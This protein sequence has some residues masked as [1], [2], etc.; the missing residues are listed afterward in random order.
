MIKKI[1]TIGLTLILVLGLSGCVDEEI[2]DTDGDG[3]NDDVDMF[4]DNPD[5]WDDTDEDGYGDNSDAFPADASEHLDSDGDGVGDNSDK[6]KYDASASIDSDNDGYP[7]GWNDGKDQSDSTSVPPLEIDFFPYDS[8]KWEKEDW[9]E[10][11]SYNLGNETL[12]IEEDKQNITS[13]KWKIWYDI[14]DNETLGF[15]IEEKQNQSY[16]D[17]HGTWWKNITDTYE[18][19]LTDEMF[20]VSD[21]FPQEYRFSMTLTGGSAEVKIYE[22]KLI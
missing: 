21:E 16:F 15:I 20:Y 17:E 6:F 2:T 11:C 9:V 18:L 8:T 19:N 10:L 22:W 12:V 7:D 3:Y 13:E 1:I 5:E 4:P 14:S